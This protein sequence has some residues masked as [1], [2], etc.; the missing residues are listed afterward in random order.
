MFVGYI[1]TYI[2]YGIASPRTAK[3]F[4]FMH[5][6]YVVML[7]HNHCLDCVQCALLEGSGICLCTANE[8]MLRFVAI[9]TC[10]VR[11]LRLRSMTL[12]IYGMSIDFG[13][14]CCAV[15]RVYQSRFGTVDHILGSHVT[16]YM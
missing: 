12:P 8:R 15:F 5:S 3:G 10:N 4:E 9:I 2:V 14:M 7:P 11:K 6:D 13:D 1:Y 16:H